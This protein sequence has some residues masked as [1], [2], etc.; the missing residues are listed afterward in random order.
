MPVLQNL[1]QELLHPWPRAAAWSW[2]LEDPEEEKERN[3][4]PLFEHNH[5]G[6]RIA[7]SKLRMLGV[8]KRGEA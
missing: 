6:L 1:R 8:G 5:P 7:V 3:L 4:D 2:G